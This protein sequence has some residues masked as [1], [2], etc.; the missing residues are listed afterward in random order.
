MTG[1]RLAVAKARF[2]EPFFFVAGF[3]AAFPLYAEL[4]F[5]TVVSP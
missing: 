5:F 4:V 3:V 1:F 2:G